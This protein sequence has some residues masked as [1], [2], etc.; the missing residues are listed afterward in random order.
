M[1]INICLKNLYLKNSKED[2][3]NSHIK[4]LRDCQELKNINSCLTCLE[5]LECTLMQDYVYAVYK[6]MNNNM[7]KD[8]GFEF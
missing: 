5:C 8:T 2:T 7:D 4:L 6:S 1:N 3:I